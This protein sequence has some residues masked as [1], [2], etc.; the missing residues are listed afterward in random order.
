[1][2]SKL[3]V[4]ILALQ[5]IWLPATLAGKETVARQVRLGDV[6]TVEGVRDNLL[7]GYGMVVGLNGTGDRQQTVFSVQTLA[8]LMQ[9]MGVQFTASAVVVKNVAAVFV[10][11]TLP[12]FARPGTPIDVTASSIGDAK[13]LEGGLLLFT[14][15]H[16]P[17]GQIYATAQGPLVNGGYSAGGRGN[18]VQINHPTTARIPGGGIVERD[19]AMDL[20]HLTQLFLLLRIS[21]P[22]RRPL[23]SL[24]VHWEKARRGH[25]TA[26]ALKF[27]FPTPGQRW[28]QDSWRKWRT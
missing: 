10:T 4:G 28:F 9:K 16:G 21:R 12:P 25:S 26:A 1:M 27:E 20:S 19:A 8:N 2:R 3:W 18:S 24:S 14:T 7:I 5:I 13:S 17:D 11:A 22:L 6:S 23:R 15:L